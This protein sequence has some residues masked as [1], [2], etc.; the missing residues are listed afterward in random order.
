VQTDPDDVRVADQVAQLRHNLTNHPPDAE[1]VELMEELVELALEYGTGLIENCPPSREQSLAVTH[2]EQSLM[3]G[4]AAIA[5][6]T[7]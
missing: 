1:K 5:R 4:R 6:A 7:S 2:L 3:W